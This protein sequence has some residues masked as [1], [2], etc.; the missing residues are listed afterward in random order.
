VLLGC[1]VSHHNGTVNWPAVFRDGAR[2]TF[3]KATQ[4]RGYVDP[5][6]LTHV[7]G[8]RSAGLLVGAYHFL[9]RAPAEAQVRNF[10]LAVQEAGGPEGMLLALD[11][12]DPGS[13]PE[14]RWSDVT[15][16]VTE[17]RRRL[18]KHPLFVYSGNWFWADHLG[19]PDART[20]GCP[21][22]D[23][24]YLSTGGGTAGAVSRV[25]EA[26]WTARYGRFGQ[27]TILQFTDAGRLGGEPHID[28]NAYRG[29]LDQLRAYAYSNPAEDEE[30]MAVSDEDAK[31]IARA[32]VTY[33]AA[34]PAAHVPPGSPPVMKRLIDF[35]RYGDH[36]AIGTRK[37]V[38][39]EST[40]L[41]GRLIDLEGKVNA[42]AST[43]GGVIDT[44]AVAEAVAAKL[45]KRLES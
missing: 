9:T 13:E 45:A 11:V 29:T 32:V 30:P 15:A 31:K 12:E 10:L 36:L 19:N 21:L 27:A 7:A 28:I 8:A 42:L 41:R 18:P 5:K 34:D 23:S 17:F 37:V 39:D 16:F 35:I 26:W 6:F 1:D 14:P 38:T 33:E 20:L 24:R 4:G 2:F 25:P 40:E 43:G 22:W 44:D 3:A